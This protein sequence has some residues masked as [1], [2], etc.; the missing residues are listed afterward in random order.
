MIEKSRGYDPVADFWA[1]YQRRH[2]RQHRVLVDLALDKCEEAMEFCDWDGFA[3][4]HRIYMR[5]RS[6][7]A[8]VQQAVNP[9]SENMSA[10]DHSALRLGWQR[11]LIV[12]CRHGACRR[13]LLGFR[14]RLISLPQF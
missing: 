10:P 9:M 7:I 8:P 6:K 12:R 13:K 3:Y 5:E 2:E 11:Y 14:A 4:W 1:W